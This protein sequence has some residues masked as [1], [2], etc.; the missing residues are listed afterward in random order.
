MSTY[1]NIRLPADEVKPYRAVAKATG[2]PLTRL[3][4]LAMKAWRP[5]LEQTNRI[6]EEARKP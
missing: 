5:R 1:E 4:A 3:I 2:I 6:M